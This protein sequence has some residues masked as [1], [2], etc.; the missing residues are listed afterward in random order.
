MKFY[1]EK[2]NKLFDSAQECEAE[3]EK[4]KLQEEKKAKEK[5]KVEKEKAA[6]AKE[7]EEIYKKI[8]DLKKAYNEKVSDFVKTYGSFHFT[9]SNQDD[10]IDEIFDSFFFKSF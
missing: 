1:S 10:F 4:V 2:L 6:K 5:E 7:I 8:Q 9:F 3:E